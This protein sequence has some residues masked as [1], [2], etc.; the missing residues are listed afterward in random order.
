[1]KCQL[2]NHQLIAYKERFKFQFI[3]VSLITNEWSGA[4]SCVVC[5]SCGCRLV[6]MVE[7]RRGLPLP[8][9]SSFITTHLDPAGKLQGTLD[10]SII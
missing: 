8:A 7:V 6:I 1:M 9:D 10:E 5:L 3:L 2:V 4:L